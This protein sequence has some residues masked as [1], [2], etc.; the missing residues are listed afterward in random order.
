[1]GAAHLALEIVDSRYQDFKFA[2][3]DVVADNTS[4]AGWVLGARIERDDLRL[5]GVWIRKN[6]ELMHTGAG[7]AALGDPL[8][9][10]AAL[11]E[12]VP[13]GLPAGALV[14]TGGLTASV[15]LERGDCIEAECGTGASAS[16]RVT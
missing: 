1:V 11:A 2:L 3:P 15:P 4:A 8:R 12:V 9:S 10:V 7:A 16:L 14:F 13:G 5:L 6:G